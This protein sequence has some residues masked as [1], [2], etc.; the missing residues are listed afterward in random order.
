MVHNRNAVTGQMDIKFNKVSPLIQVKLQWHIYCHHKQLTLSPAYC[1]DRLVFSRSFADLKNI[2]IVTRAIKSL[3]LTLG[4]RN[5]HNPCVQCGPVLLCLSNNESMKPACWYRRSWGWVSQQDTPLFK[6]F[7]LKTLS[8]W[9]ATDLSSVRPFD[10]SDLIW[11]FARI[12]DYRHWC[13]SM[14][15]RELCQWGLLSQN[16]PWNRMP[17]EQL[18]KCK[19]R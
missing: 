15:G 2:R 12:H 8:W 13:H 4:N 14:R 5:F 19:R 10:D 11:R 3:T 1:S 17:V 18:L 9:Q 7:L 16:A 6:L